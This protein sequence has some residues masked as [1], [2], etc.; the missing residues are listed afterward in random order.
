M[1]FSKEISLALIQG[2]EQLP[3]K[4]DR[5]VLGVIG[6]V[7]TQNIYDIA[8]KAQA[9]GIGLLVAISGLVN[10]LML[11]GSIYM[12]Q[13]YDRVL[14]S[15]SI[16]TLLGLFGIVLLIYCF[17]GLFDLTRQRLLAR[18]SVRLDMTLGA[19]CF[20]DWISV[21]EH[22]RAHEG[23]EQPPLQQLVHLRR[24]LS[25]PAFVS[26]CDM[27]FV[28]IFL[29]AL[30]LIHPWLGT[31]VLAAAALACGMVVFG[32]WLTR[33]TGIASVAQDTI[34]TDMSYQSRRLAEPLRAMRM[35]DDLAAYW[36]GLQRSSL[37][38]H[39]RLHSAP[40]ALAA[41]SKTFRLMLQSAILTVGAVLVIQGKISAGMI[42]A[43]SIL[44][45]RV[46][47]PIDQITGGWRLIAGGWAA[48]RQLH[49]YFEH[50]APTLE[51]VELPAPRGRISVSSV[52]Q[53]PV[54]PRGDGSQYSLQ[55]I[56]FDLQPGDGLCILG[57][58]DAGKSALAK[59]LVGISQP[60]AGE[61]RFDA[62]KLSL[63]PSSQIGPAIG[64]LPEMVELLP[65]TIFDN[66]SRFRAEATDAQVI[67]AAKLARVHDE[68]MA[69][70]D[71]YSTF[72]G[73]GEQSV[74]SQAHLQKIGL[75]RTLVYDPALIVLDDPRRSL[76]RCPDV[77]EIV[78]DVTRQMRNKSCTV[79]ITAR[80]PCAI[81]ALNKVLILSDGR[82]KRFG[83]TE[84]VLGQPYP[85]R[86]AA[87]VRTLPSRGNGT[88]QVGNR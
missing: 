68:I 34:L 31:M 22:S 88:A 28:P 74:L 3:A 57:G 27:P 15:G 60:T 51:T 45:G 46:L 7:P 55:D 21:Q 1:Q 64:Y 53:T 49:T 36:L 67:S 35:Q 8:L 50:Y 17:L 29:M 77:E 11:T 65:A 42:M 12:I 75:A 78:H 81:S 73:R 18:I 71:G 63:W 66:I 16:V 82:M 84:E 69:L 48:H 59:L 76:C 61:V 20:G 80:Q 83:P 13:I 23:G 19:A 38:W 4:N 6:N 72:L 26:V 52:S 58:L 86:V 47:A 41:F 9:G 87:K 39:Q 24:L 30:Y 2:R 44:A 32:R 5:F 33:R 79:V 25:S 85:A 43:A 62:V 37:V 70:P 10:L 56:S 40:D 14:P 54:P